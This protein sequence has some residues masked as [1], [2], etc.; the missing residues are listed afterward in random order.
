VVHREQTRQ[1]YSAL[2]YLTA[3]VLAELPLDSFFAA[4]FTTVLKATSGLCISWGK[5][6]GTFSLLTVASASLGFFISSWS[7][8]SGS[9]AL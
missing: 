8:P 6:T 2:E 7:P 1:Q 5:V 9:L 3:K 4:V